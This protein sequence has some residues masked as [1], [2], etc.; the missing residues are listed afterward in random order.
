[1]K[2]WARIHCLWGKGLEQKL[3]GLVSHALRG[4]SCHTAHHIRPNWDTTI[5]RPI[6]QY[7]ARA[8]ML[9]RRNQAPAEEG[10]RGRGRP[11]E[12]EA[13]GESPLDGVV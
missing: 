7:T 12:A 1:M 3:V 4:G 9:P 6:M 5:V 2:L 13:W 11:D 8:I 10:G